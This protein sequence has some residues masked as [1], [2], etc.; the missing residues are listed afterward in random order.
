LDES[1]SI[2]RLGAI[3]T[4]DKMKTSNDYEIKNFI[5]HPKFRHQDKNDLG[6]VELYSS[7]EYV[8]SLLSLY[9]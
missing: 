8:Y 3:S 2:A 7:I 9:N 4:S 1:P 6:L 5:Q